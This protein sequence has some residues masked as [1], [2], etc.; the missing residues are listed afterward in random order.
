MILIQDF[1]CDE[2]CIVCLKA[3]T[4]LDDCGEGFWQAVDLKGTES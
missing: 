1:L 2:I 3:K 4:P